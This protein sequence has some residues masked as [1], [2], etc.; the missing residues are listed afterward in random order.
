MSWLHYGTVAAIYGTV[1]ASCQRPR[2][3]TPGGVAGYLYLAAVQQKWPEK[4]GIAC[5]LGLEDSI[6]QQPR[7][8]TMPSMRGP[9]AF[10]EV[11]SLDSTQ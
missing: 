11:P 7:G 1:A 10:L 6:L 8:H 2:D 9:R 5:S 3:L 4:C